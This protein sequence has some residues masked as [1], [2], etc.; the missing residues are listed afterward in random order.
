MAQPLSNLFDDYARFPRSQNR[1]AAT[2]K[3]FRFSFE[4][5]LRF[6]GE[7]GMESTRSA[8]TT[9]TME[10]YPIWLRETPS[11]PQRGTTLRAGAGIRACLRDLRAFASQTHSNRP[12]LW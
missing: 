11:H 5:F 2:I 10:S 1:V 3:R 4:T 8:L 6:L 7:T 12:E 9:E